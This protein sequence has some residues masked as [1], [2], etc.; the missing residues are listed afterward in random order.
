MLGVL[1]WEGYP[2]VS[3]QLVNVGPS[4]M[5]GAAQMPHPIGVCSELDLGINDLYD[6]YCSWV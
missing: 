6:I 2:P 3:R 4:G 5:R 1:C